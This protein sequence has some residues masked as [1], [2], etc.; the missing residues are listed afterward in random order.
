[1]SFYLVC[2][3]ITPQ[4]MHGQMTESSL[5]PEWDAAD[6]IDAR[7]RHGTQTNGMIKRWVRVTVLI[8]PASLHVHVRC[9]PMGVWT[10]RTR[11]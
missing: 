10:H 11:R 3:D 4:A 9:T 6:E 7:L 5:P 1:M 8:P 2:I